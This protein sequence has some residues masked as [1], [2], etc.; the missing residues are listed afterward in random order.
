MKRFVIIDGKSVFY[1]GYYAMPDLK[2]KDGI[3]TGGVYGFAVMA[4][5]VLRKLKPDYVCVAWDKPKTNIR[6]RLELYS[7]YKAGRKPAPADFY[8]QIP[9]LHELLDAFGWPLYELDDYEADDIMGTLALQATKKDIETMLVTSDL[10][11]LQLISSHT[12]AYILKTGL[13]NIEQYDVAFFEKKHG[14]KVEQFLDYK[15]L[16]GDASDNIPGVPGIGNKS[17]VEL[18][19]QYPTLDDIY[20]N[21]ALIKSTL[22]SKLEAGRKSAYMSHKLA[23]IWLDAPI[24][25]DLQAVDGSKSKPEDIKKILSNLEFRS[26]INRLPEVFK[27]DGNYLSTVDIDIKIPKAVVIDSDEKLQQ[28]KVS[29]EDKLVIHSRARG[30]HGENPKVLLIDDTSNCYV[31][32]V[33]KIKIDTLKD[34]FSYIFKSDR[35]VIGYDLKN[36]L[37]IGYALGFEIGFVE[38]DVLI[39]AFLLNPLN[40]VSSIT[41]LAQINLNYQASS[42]DDL[43]EIDFIQ[44]APEI[45]GVIRQ[46]AKLQVAEMAKLKK[47]NS[48]AKDIEWKIIPILA[49]ME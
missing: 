14:I 7:K 29:E 32:L 6:K 19:N 38:H 13:S 17:A 37:E 16:V 1:R 30:K 23:E 5:E 3:P 18:L 27:V 2:T 8:Q 43:D 36:S 21:L 31:V 41:Q 26:L 11:V 10:D 47:I 48:L 46:I 45:T 15:S 49:E 22:V 34:K 28:L 35:G 44:K 24:E 9:I 39:G 40:R 20:T 25:L 33:D 12:K 4:L 42:L